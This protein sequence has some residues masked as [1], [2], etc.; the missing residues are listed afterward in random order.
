MTLAL[1]IG[2]SSRPYY[3]KGRVA[4]VVNHPENCHLDF[5]HV[6]LKP[7]IVA[8]SQYQRPRR[9][10]VGPGPSAALAVSDPHWDKAAGFV[11]CPHYRS[12]WRTE[13]L[14]LAQDGSERGFVGSMVRLECCAAELSVID[15]LLCDY[16]ACDNA[17]PP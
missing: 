11:S 13:S 14:G 15:P 9:V 4:D 7:V 5:R 3:G 2:S 10:E 16:Q 17:A 8:G 1:V 6:A 12:C